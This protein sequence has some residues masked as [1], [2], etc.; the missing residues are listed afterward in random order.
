MNKTN[1]PPAF[2]S[3]TPSVEAHPS[4]SGVGI[5][6]CHQSTSHTVVMCPN[7]KTCWRW[8]DAMCCEHRLFLFFF[9]CCFCVLFLWCS[10]LCRYIETAIENASTQ[11]IPGMPPQALGVG[12]GI[13]CIQ[14]DDVK[15]VSGGRDHRVKLW[16]M[17]T[18]K[19]EREFVGHTGSV[20]CLQF[21]DTKVISGS[22]DTNI[23]VWDLETGERTG[24]LTDHLQSVLHLNFNDDRL[25]SCSKDK[26]IIVWLWDTSA[27][28]YIHE[29]TLGGHTA[30]VNV[31][32]F[33]SR[34]IVSASGD[35]TIRIWH[36]D[37]GEELDELSGHA[38]GIACLQF[39]GDYIVSGSSDKSLKVW[40]INSGNL[41]PDTAVH[42]QDGSV[43][44]HALLRTLNG[45]KDLVRCVRFDVAMDRIV[46]GSYDHSIM[47]RMT[48]LHTAIVCGPSGTLVWGAISAPPPPSLSISLFVNEVR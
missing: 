4:S 16:N 28:Q 41:N 20:L 15:I 37:T 11:T 5:Q 33:D 29:H 9:V 8:R 17:F 38:R 13:Y 6:L 34:F 1:N 12:Q 32:E 23:M 31:V 25:V 22:S 19:L 48:L 7:P 35:R 46:S 47:V 3:T 27:M 40:K 44:K 39:Q 26:Q 43:R 42:E 21:D 2:H 45:H 24:V 30:A 14:F 18:H 10:L 36:T